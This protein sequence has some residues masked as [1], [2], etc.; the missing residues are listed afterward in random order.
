MLMGIIKHVSRI[1]RKGLLACLVRVTIVEDMRKIV[2]LGVLLLSQVG[3]MSAYRQTVG[4]DTT[5][6]FNR[7]YLTDFNT[8]WQAVLDALKSCRL[9]VVNREGGY[10]LTKWTDNTSEKNF[11][12]SYG[13][14][15][16]Y[17][18][19]Q[20]RFKVTVGKGFYNGH[21]SVKIFVIK[22]Q[23]VQRDVL[24]GWRPIESDSI[25][26]NTMLYRVGRLIH[27]RM[28]IAKIEEEKTRKAIESS[29]F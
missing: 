14:A 6:G 19:T 17:L 4:G 22:E 13:S 3:C 8:A 29:G 11:T 27:M 10:L 5:Q 21:P 9:D 23:L 25:D 24:E 15:N 12:D 16:A 18:K 26:E 28:K 20:F 2:I 7:V 1:K